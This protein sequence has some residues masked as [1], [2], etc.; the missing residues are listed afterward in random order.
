[1]AT[2]TPKE[3][4]VTPE[5]TPLASVSPGYAFVDSV[6]QVTEGEDASV[7]VV[8]GTDGEASVR[9]FPA[10]LDDASAPPVT[11]AFV[12][13]A[14]AVRS[15]PEEDVV[16]EEVLPT[17]QERRIVSAAVRPSQPMGR[18][19][20]EGPR[21]SAG[22]PPSAQFA[23]VTKGGMP[24]TGHVVGP[25][26]LR[27]TQSISDDSS[28]GT[29]TDEASASTNDQ[30]SPSSEAPGALWGATGWRLWAVILGALCALVAILLIIACRVCKDDDSSAEAKGA[31]SGIVGAS[32]LQTE[33]S[34]ACGTQENPLYEDDPGDMFPSDGPEP[35][36]E[37]VSTK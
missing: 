20:S 12:V 33:R 1:M 31:E 9:P 15:E 30:P 36:I 3:T 34:S 11:D 27:L 18:I 37:D 21:P 35:P 26:A 25:S 28:T 13:S 19:V 6:E 5:E 16:S 24:V 4:P 10:T 14:E 8:L 7:L 2:L 17:E 22:V 23:D 32:L 29:T